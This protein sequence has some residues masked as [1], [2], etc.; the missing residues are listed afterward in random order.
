MPHLGRV[1]EFDEAFQSFELFVTANGTKEE[2]K[3][4]TFLTVI[5]DRTYE[6]LKNLAALD[7]PG[8]KTYSEIKTV[9]EEHCGP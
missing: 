4:V 6:V 1:L 3:A 5:G 7:V 8:A 9:L 2:K